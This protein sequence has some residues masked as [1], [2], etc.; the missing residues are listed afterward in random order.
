M[1]T[2]LFAFF[3]S[4]LTVSCARDESRPA[5]VKSTMNASSFY[6]FSM[7]S[8]DG[9]LIPFSQFKGKKVL[10]V[11]TASECG[12]TG[13]YE[14]LQ[15]LHNQYGGKVAII[16]FP[17]NDFGGQEP[18]SNEEIKG[19]CSKNYGVSFLMM[20]KVIAKIYYIYEVLPNL[21]K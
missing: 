8:I 13:Q 20:E 10:L 21:L 19:F 12:Y 6:D 18:G 5:D 15:K 17:A 3:I 9:E 14:G 1:K 11:N 7:K 16:G 4:V 2:L